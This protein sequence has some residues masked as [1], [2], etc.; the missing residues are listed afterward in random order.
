MLEKAI[1]WYKKLG[2]PEEYD[3]AFFALTERVSLSE[4]DEENPVGYLLEKDDYGLN[5]VYFLA[6]CEEMYQAFCRRKVPESVFYDC[7]RGLVAE[8][9][10]CLQAFG[11]I[12]VYEVGWFYAVVNRQSVIRIGRL[13]FGMEIAGEWCSGGKVQEGDKILLVHIP[14][15]EELSDA[16]CYRS[17]RDAERFFLRYYPEFDFKCFV[18]GSWMLD[19]SLDAFL[20]EKSNIR[21]FRKLFTHYRT[22][23]SDS[24]I[25]FVFGRCVTREN[26]HSF[27]PVTRLQSELQ[28]HIASGGKLYAAFGTRERG[29]EDVAGIDCHYHQV[30]WFS[31][32]LQDYPYVKECADTGNILQGACDYM[33]I[34]KL[35]A[36]NILC[37]PNM[38]QLFQARDITQNILGG[39]VKCEN[40]QAYAYG[41]LVYPEF[42]ARKDYGFKEQAETLVNMGFDGIKLIET[43]PN[44]HK[45]VGLPV[46][47]ADYEDFFQYLERQQ[48]PILWHAN[49]PV[50]LW[51]KNAVFAN[52]YAPFEQIQSEVLTVLN[53][54]P[55][56]CVVL[57]H[58]FFMA[59]DLKRLSQILDAYKN[60][61]VDITPAEEE[62]GF[63]TETYEESC[64]FFRR[65][66]DK[67]LFGTDNKNAFRPEFKDDKVSMLRRFL[68]TKDEFSGLIYTLR[69]VGLEREEFEKILYRN[70]EK[71]NGERP[72]PMDR[73][74]FGEYIEAMLPQLPEGQTKDRIIQ[75]MQEKL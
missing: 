38:S 15:G 21:N 10:A 14:A 33:E 12:G 31:T 42:P 53:R 58:F 54:H 60:V 64:R 68:R 6:Q 22:E 16:A 67:I 74:A 20:G 9:Q 36:V 56:L 8:A 71:R 27:V 51:K 45:L 47:A 72:K 39:I 17:L 50:F 25:K 7:A 4:I 18:C 52:C 55:D 37:M 26:I 62:L 46:C 65:Y 73:K 1:K 61:A 3:K 29:F 34:S 13:N 69:G 40:P 19:E 44:A 5:L 66:A 28:K 59:W 70:F 41:G 24:A 35:K 11:A 32:D 48:I 75:Y 23:E 57:A 43:K 30:Q 2:F 63:L 49:D